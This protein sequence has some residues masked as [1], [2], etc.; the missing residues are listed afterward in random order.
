MFSSCKKSADNSKHIPKDATAVFSVDMAA[1]GKKMAWELL[2]GSDVFKQMTEK[3]G[4]DSSNISDLQ[5]AGIDF[6][7]T[8]YTYVVADKRSAGGQR[9]VGLVPLSD[10]G[11]WEAYVKKTFP[12]AQIKTVDKRKE[13]EL[14]EGMYAGWDDNMLVLMNTV[15]VQSEMPYDENGNYIA[16]KADLAQTAAEMDNVFKMNEDNSIISRKQYKELAT[17]GHDMHLWVNYENI[18]NNYGAGMMG[19]FT[20]SSAMMKDAALAAGINFEKGAIKGDMKYY[21]SAE[22]KDVMKDLLGKKVDKEMVDRLPANN[23]NVLAAMSLS[24]NNL[25]QLLDK[26]GL[27]GMANVALSEQNLTADD[28]FEAFTGDMVFAMNNFRLEQKKYGYMHYNEDMQEV[29]DSMTTYDPA[30]DW[31]YVMKINKQDKFDKL[32]QLAMSTGMLTS[33][34]N[35]SYNL[36]NAGSMPMQIMVKDKY[37]AVATGTGANAYMSGAN[38]GQ[39]LH[40]VAAKEVNDHPFCM[41]FDIRQMLKAV[42]PETMDDEADKARFAEVQKLMD[43]AVFSGGEFK[44]DAFEYKMLVNFNNK[45]ENSLMQLIQMANRMSE[46]EKKKEPMTAAR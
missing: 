31:I 6:M 32:M 42:G 11:D 18:M 13:A 46:I 5:H 37:L 24:P 22:M 23:L 41:F 29:T 19:G 26:F 21:V 20:M 10:A 17:A 9:V 1:I 33:A 38:K 40:E 2:F 28:V 34:G 16:P 35:G 12:K 43:N 44:G 39:K 14:A 25:K 7:N 8:F 27:L 36:V 45:D 3:A 30:M 15:T 4:K